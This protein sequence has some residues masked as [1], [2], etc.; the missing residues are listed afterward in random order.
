[1]NRNPSGRWSEI[2]SFSE[3]VEQEEGEEEEEEEEEVGEEAI[4]WA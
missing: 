3:D 4:L 1:M 2:W